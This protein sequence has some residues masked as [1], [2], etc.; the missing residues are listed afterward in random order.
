[1]RSGD[2]NAY[3]KQR[4]GHDCSAKDFRTWKATVLAAVAVGEDRPD[5][6]EDHVYAGAE[7]PDRQ[8]RAH[9]M[10]TGKAAFGRHVAELVVDARLVQ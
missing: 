8:E 4:A 9:Q 7:Q 2:V 3:L 5:H 10:M 6:R 1:M